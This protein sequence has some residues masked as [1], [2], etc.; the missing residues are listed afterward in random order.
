MLKENFKTRITN[1]VGAMSGRAGIAIFSFHYLPFKVYGVERHV[2]RLSNF[3]SKRGITV[4]VITRGYLGSPSYEISESGVTIVRTP[5]FSVP[6]GGGRIAELLDLM[7][8]TLSAPLLALKL[9]KRKSITIMHGNGHYGGGWQAALA[10]LLTRRPFTVTIHGY[11]I[12]YYRGHKRLPPVL[13]FLKRAG[14]IIVQKET[15]ITILKRWGI[16]EERIFYIEEGAIDADHFRPPTDEERQ[17]LCDNERRIVFV[18]RLIRFKDPL[19]L[20]EA[21]PLI[22]KHYPNVRF[23]FAG[24][25]YLRPVIERRA[26]ELGVK[27]RIT[28]LGQV[29]DVRPV[30][31]SADVFVALSPYNNFSDL[32]MLEAMACGLPVVA[33]NSGET[34]KIIKNGWNGLLTKPR[35]PADLAEKVLMILK[36]PVLAQ[37][38]GRNARKTV[39]DRYNLKSFSRKMLEAFLKGAKS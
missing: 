8:Y 16:P 21:A 24:E 11:G 39:L 35:N 36:D 12:D 32:A 31:W 20:I 3:L 28:L 4:I 30:Y 33:T 13:R 5:S 7:F 37:R 17:R 10:S 23:V 29:L 34:Y 25:G 19:L 15:A 26:E 22:L 18:G 38:L 9:T 14:A 1:L 27:D 6:K 2:E